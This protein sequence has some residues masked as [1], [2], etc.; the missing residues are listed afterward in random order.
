MTIQSVAL[1]AG[2][3]L[4]D[5]ALMTIPFR[6]VFRRMACP[7]P[8]WLLALTLPRIAVVAGLLYLIVRFRLGDPLGLAL[9]VLLALAIIVPS[10][11]ALRTRL[12]SWI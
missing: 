10:L 4:L 1:G 9:G 2:V 5:A 6:I 3:M 11:L 8:P 7:R 12:S